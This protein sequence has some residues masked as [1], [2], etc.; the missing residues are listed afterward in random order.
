MKEIQ[1]GDH[2]KDTVTGLKG[3]A[4][5]R[6]EWLYGCRRITVQPKVDTDGK[7]PDSVTF[8]EPQLVLV[9]R[10]K[11]PAKK[12]TTGGPGPEPTRQITPKRY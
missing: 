12:R 11:T 8:D 6:S 3:V 7:V 5:G 2:V 1:L 10:A 9:R 4:V